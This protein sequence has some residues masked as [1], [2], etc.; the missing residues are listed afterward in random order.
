[1]ANIDEIKQIINDPKT[2]KIV[3]TVGVDDVPHTA[4]KQSLHVN[5]EGKIE[6]I[7]LFESSESYRNVT[8]SLWYNKKV[9]V[10]I[11]S[12]D[13]ESYEIIG[14]PERILIAGREYEAVYTKVLEEKGYDIAAVVT[15]APES[16]E[17]SSPKE[18]FKDQEKTRLFYKHLDR[19]SKES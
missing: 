15:I 14:E 7:E 11:L 10:L 13:K 19:L 6:Y 8:A 17:N 12:P 16:V 2:V 9:S 18:K 1:M 5:D 3:G 4:V